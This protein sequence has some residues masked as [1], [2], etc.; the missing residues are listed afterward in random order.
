MTDLHPTFYDLD[1]AYHEFY[2]TLFAYIHDC[3]GAVDERFVASLDV[4]LTAIRDR[5]DPIAPC[6]ACGCF[7]CRCEEGD[8]G[9]QIMARVNAARGRK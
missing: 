3:G 9:W 2:N 8:E 7:P 6:S 5:L 4:A 1:D